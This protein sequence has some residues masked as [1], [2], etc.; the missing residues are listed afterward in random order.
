MV[1]EARDTLTSQQGILA[2]YRREIPLIHVKYIT[3][4]AISKSALLGVPWWLSGLRI[5]HFT[6]MALVT[7]VQSLARELLHAMHVAPKKYITYFIIIKLPHNFQLHH[8]FFTMPFYWDY[9]ILEGS[10]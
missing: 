2:C 9:V 6:A 10:H 1:P 7:Q 4:L 3:Y 5:C 8:H